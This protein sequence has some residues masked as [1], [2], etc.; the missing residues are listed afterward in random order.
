MIA[1]DMILESRYPDA[2]KMSSSTGHQRTSA[3]FPEIANNRKARICVQAVHNGTKENQST[4][5]AQKNP[6][7]VSHFKNTTCFIILVIFRSVI[8]TPEDEK[9][10]QDGPGLGTQFLFIGAILVFFSC[11]PKWN[12]YNGGM[13]GFSRTHV[14]MIV[15]WTQR[16]A[17]NAQRKKRKIK[18][19]SWLRKSLSKSLQPPKRL[20]IKILTWMDL[21][22]EVNSPS[23]SGYSSPKHNEY[24]YIQKWNMYDEIFSEAFRDDCGMDTNMECGSARIQ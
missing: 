19:P 5:L 14:G 6:E 22:P 11:N 12:I 23:S 21:D 24:G 8:K 9:C 15:G 16:V 13:L 2:K 3:M 7:A 1:S 4:E 20:K 17:L 18:V 10:D